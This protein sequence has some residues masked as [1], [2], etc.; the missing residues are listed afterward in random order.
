MHTQHSTCS[1]DGLVAGVELGLSRAHV[2]QAIRR[3]V[4]EVPVQVPKRGTLYGTHGFVVQRRNQNG[5]QKLP[6]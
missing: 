5:M 3:A 2:H 4:I 6:S 1:D